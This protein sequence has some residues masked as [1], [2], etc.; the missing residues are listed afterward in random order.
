MGRFGLDG[1][2]AKAISQIRAFTCARWHGWRPGSKGRPELLVVA[3]G[4]TRRDDLG[5]AAYIFQGRGKALRPTALTLFAR[6]LLSGVVD[7]QSHDG[8]YV[9]ATA[10]GLDGIGYEELGVLLHHSPA[11]AMP[12]RYDLSAL[13]RSEEAAE[14]FNR[15]VDAGV[16]GLVADG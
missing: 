11:S 1:G 5:E 2:T 3:Y 16:L 7:M 14:R 10:L 8:R 6:V 4:D 9:F 15:S 12:K 13:I